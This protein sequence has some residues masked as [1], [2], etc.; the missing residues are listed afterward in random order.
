MG[1]S[2][3]CNYK[4]RNLVEFTGKIKIKN[5]WKAKAVP[6]VIETNCYIVS[7]I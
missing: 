3:N 1:G 2:F 6:E 7:M 4:L 5:I